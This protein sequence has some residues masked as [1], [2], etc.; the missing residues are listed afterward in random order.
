MERAVAEQGATPGAPSAVSAPSQPSSVQ[1]MAAELV[2]LDAQDTR[3][4]DSNTP[5]ASD[6]KLVDINTASVD[7]LNSLGGRDGLGGRSSLAGPMRPS[8]TSCRSG[9]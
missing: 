6:L 4:M 1:P 5:E 9:C 2:V 7:E 3:R 8:T